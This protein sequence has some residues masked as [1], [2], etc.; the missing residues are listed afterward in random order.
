[1]NTAT[2]LLG[3]PL[4]RAIEE[5]IAAQVAKLQQAGV[6]PSLAIVDATDDEASKR[7]ARMKM[8][9]ASRL[10]I[11]SCLHSFSVK[12]LD[13][14]KPSGQ[15][16][17]EAKKSF[18]RLLGDLGQDPKVHGIFIER[19]LPPELDTLAWAARV[20][21]KKDVEG[22]HPVNIGKLFLGYSTHQPNY[23][24]TTALACLEML[25]FYGISL[26]G[27]HA[28][29]VG[30]S[31]TVGKPLAWLMLNENATVTICHSQTVDLARYTR[32]ADVLVVAAGHPHLVEANMISP[33]A[34]ILDVGVNYGPDGTI[35]GDVNFAS[36]CQVASAIT[37]PTGGLGP[38]TTALL[39]ENVV[40][41]A[42]MQ[43]SSLAEEQYCLD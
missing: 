32:A 19:P 7:Y 35:C 26:A 29:I 37:P 41:A 21:A 17:C 30:R 12:A 18:L 23:V 42:Q 6:T 10:G 4:V 43:R 28:V 15:A 31:T 40:K 24:P 5:R 20:P 3:G 13:A 8:R 25:K 36:A 2:T 16:R 27:K 39:L 38:V 11:D 22:E 1:M 14:D 33:G 9:L 34:V